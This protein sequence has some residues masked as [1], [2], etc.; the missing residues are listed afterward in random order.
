M[1]EEKGEWYEITE[2]EERGGLDTPS[3][4]DPTPVRCSARTPRAPQYP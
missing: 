1:E 4:T 3:P 2:E